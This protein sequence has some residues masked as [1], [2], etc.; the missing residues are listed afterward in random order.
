MS[1][2]SLLFSSDEGTSRSLGQALRELELEVEVCPEIFATVEK[3]TSNKVDLLVTDWDAGL[4]A[5]FLLKTC[6]EVKSSRNSF[7]IVVASPTRAAA[8][9]K[10]GADLVLCKPIDADT[11]KYA[12]LAC[13]EFL[14]RMDN[15]FGPEVAQRLTAQA[16]SV[17]EKQLVAEPD[18]EALVE[19]LSGSPELGPMALDIQ[20][21]VAAPMDVRPIDDA[22]FRSAGIQG[23]FHT[24]DPKV[25]RPRVGHQ[26]PRGAVARR[27]SLGVAFFVTL[28]ISISPAR[29]EAVASVCEQALEKTHNWL[30]PPVD[31]SSFKEIQVQENQS[32]GSSEKR[33]TKQIEVVP[34]P[35]PYA[36]A[37]VDAPMPRTTE[38]NVT[39]A[40]TPG[41]PQSSA[42]PSP[43]TKAH[44]PESM[45]VPLQGPDVHDT[46][47]KGTASLMGD[48]EPVGLSEELAQ[49]MLLEKV[50]PSYPEE[51]LKAGLKGPVV[52]QAWIG[53]D[54]KVRDLKLVNG[55]FVLGRAAA[56]A[57]RQWKFKPYL[58]NG[59]AVEAQTYLTVEFQAP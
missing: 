33:Y 47:V 38:T 58:I 25:T 13:S 52:V 9:K 2:R 7:T 11:A 57:V 18:S 15:W 51:A 4:E 10:V 41:P 34:V 14:R 26:Y 55:Y 48:V 22:L 36:P 53:R 29:C 50:L 45:R 56:Q 20:A 16:D 37:K 43:A 35:D 42:Q 5:S 19:D 39:T 49:K 8:A 46:A 1:P 28:Y 32:G 30:S 17:P 12:L 3:L 40:M 6:R 27:V 54:G 59:E 21:K 24:G 44:I 31:E 23:L